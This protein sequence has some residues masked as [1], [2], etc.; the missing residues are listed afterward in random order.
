MGRRA[1]SVYLRLIPGRCLSDRT[2]AQQLT[3]A[4]LIPIA[5]EEFATLYLLS[6]VRTVARP[7]DF[8]AKIMVFPLVSWILGCFPRI[9]REQPELSIGLVEQYAEAA[10]ALAPQLDATN[11]S[12]APIDGPVLPPLETEPFLGGRGHR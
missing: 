5:Q 9:I 6:L 11:V 10:L 1:L 2:F 4:F 7:G 12:R 8:S 3:S